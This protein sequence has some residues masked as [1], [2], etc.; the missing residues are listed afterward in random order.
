[1]SGSGPRMTHESAS[2][3]DVRPLFEAMDEAELIVQQ[4]ALEGAVAAL[5][6]LLRHQGHPLLTAALFQ[7]VRAQLDLA[8]EVCV[9]KGWQP[10]V[11]TFNPNTS[12]LH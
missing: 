4:I 7:N 2:E 1:M 3:G 11:F 5:I 12:G 8:H 10:I 6:F 9:A